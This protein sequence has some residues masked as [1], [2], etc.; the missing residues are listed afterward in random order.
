MNRTWTVS[1]SIVVDV[2][3]LAVY[4]VISNPTRTAEWSPENTG[5][6]V[7]DPRP[8]AYVGMA[9]DGTNRRGPFRWVTR[10]Y[11]TDA[12][13]GS[14]FRF[15]VRRWGV[16]KPL[17]KVPVASWDFQLEPVAN[18]TKITETWTDDRRNWPDLLCRV[19]DP[20][21]TSQPSFAD[22]NR[23]NIQTSLRRLKRQ[24]ESDS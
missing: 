14:R 16:G 1:E 3:P 12:E 20:L 4:S 22:F 7:E 8:E 15:E 5:A 17:L 21:L 18:G 9:F 19:V 24:L 13:P 2:D 6:A 23:R 10:C 11:V